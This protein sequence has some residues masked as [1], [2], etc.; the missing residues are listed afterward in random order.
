MFHFHVPPGKVQRHPGKGSSHLETTETFRCGGC[1]ADPKDAAAHA[2]ARPRRMYEESPYLRRIMRR[3][4]ESILAAGVVVASKKRLPLAPTAA[5]GNDLT[6]VNPCF[7]YEV[8]SILNQ[9][10]IYAENLFER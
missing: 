8:G 2:A 7:G 3:I 9:L 5:P 10:R 4:K 6:M 1:F